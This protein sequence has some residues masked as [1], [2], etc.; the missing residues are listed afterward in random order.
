MSTDSTMQE[1]K[2]KKGRN[3]IDNESL[4]QAFV[5]WYEKRAAA[6]AAGKPEPEP[7]RAI[8]EA[9]LLIP[10]RLATKGNFSG[11]TYRD[12]MVS[13]AIENI[14]R[15]Y[16]NFDPAKSKNPFAY[17]TQIA[18]YAF[19]RRIQIEKKNSYTKHKLIQNSGLLDAI[20]TQAQDADGDYHVSFM[21][22]LQMN[23]NP[24][25]ER[26]FEKKRSRGEKE[27]EFSIED[28]LASDGVELVEEEELPEELMIEEVGDDE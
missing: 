26:L 25:L 2:P 16:R 9:I 27:N 12:E 18:Y 23:M 7:P 8:S 28:L 21:E 10:Q 19:I 24:D 5:Q 4:Y 13:D 22:T 1:L 20:T 6:E 3:Y 11:Y 15:Y 14:V 17:F